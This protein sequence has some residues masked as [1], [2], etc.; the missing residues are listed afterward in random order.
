MTPGL[1]PFAAH[2]VQLAARALA[3]ERDLRYDPR[4]DLRA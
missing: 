2:L 3:G 1:G 4:F